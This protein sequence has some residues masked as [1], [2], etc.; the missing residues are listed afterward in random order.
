MFLHAGIKFPYFV[1]FAK[2]NGLRPGEPPKHMLTAMAVLAFFCIFLGVYP[3]PLYDI[4]PYG[5]DFKA[6][7]LDHTLNQL[8]LLMFSALAFFLLLPMLKRTETIS[9][10][11]DW[12]YRMGGRLFYRFT[13]WAFNGLNHYAAELFFKR[14]PFRLTQFFTEPGGNVQKHLLQIIN[15]GSGEEKDLSETNSH[16][17]RRSRLGTYPVGGGVLLAVIFLAALS[18]LFFT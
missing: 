8:Q 17:D 5:V 6:Y 3:Q 9:I 15:E 18:Y 10:D 1:F 7:T 14:M 4:L 12:F 2:D 11:S 16:I 13:D